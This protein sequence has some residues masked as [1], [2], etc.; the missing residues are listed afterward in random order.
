MPRSESSS[1]Y[2]STD[3]ER[4][5]CPRESSSCP[6]CRAAPPMSGTVVQHIRGKKS[7]IEGKWG[8]A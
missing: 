4:L 2:A 5:V 7:I 6:D 1:L 3:N 8:L